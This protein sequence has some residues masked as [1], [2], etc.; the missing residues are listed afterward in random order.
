M[1]AVNSAVRRVMGSRDSSVGEFGAKMQDDL[2]DAARCVQQGIAIRS[3]AVMV[4]VTAAMRRCR[5]GAASIRARLWIDI[6]GPTDLAKLIEGSSYG[7]WVS[8]WYNYVTL[9]PC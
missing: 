4:T 9:R 3:G 7:S 1:L 8:H 6:A 2:I 5:A